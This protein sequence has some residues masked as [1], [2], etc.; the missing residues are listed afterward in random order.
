MSLFYSPDIIKGICH[1]NQEESRHAI[2][3]LRL[4]KDDE[5]TIID[6]SGTFYKAI[7]TEPHQKKCQFEVSSK[8]TEA[9]RDYK[10]HIAISPTK[11]IDRIEWFVEKATEIGIDEITFL[12]CTNSERKVIKTDRLVK[13]AVSAAKQSIKAT[14]PKV[15]G[16]I[17]F[18]D[19]ITRKKPS[20]NFI[21]YVNFYNNVHLKDLV[22]PA[23]DYSVLIGPEGDFTEEEV[24][25]ASTRGYQPVSL[26]SSRL[27]TET[28][29]IT[30]C[31]L[32]HLLNSQ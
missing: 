1:L 31:H 5:L 19:F 17:P 6:G 20:Q 29:G 22:K 24:K 25:A 14:I 21:A 12:K 28:A 30:A 18:N 16:L 10:I 8:K 3:V 26:G 32:F 11:S 2:K 27:R 23:N 7:I 9:Q 13:K 15:N 4:G